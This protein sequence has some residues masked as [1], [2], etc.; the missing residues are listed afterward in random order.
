MSFTIQKNIDYLIC[1]CLFYTKIILTFDHVCSRH[2]CNHALNTFFCSCYLEKTEVG[3]CF[4]ICVILFH[5]RVNYYT[6]CKFIMD[7]LYELLIRKLNS[8][9]PP[10]PGVG[11]RF[12]NFRRHRICVCGDLSFSFLLEPY[13]NR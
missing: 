6:S 1:I 5:M 7:N 3:I 4:H 10:A 13:K 12:H 8:I 11:V 9:N 2:D